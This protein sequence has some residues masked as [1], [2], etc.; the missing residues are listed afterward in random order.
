MESTQVP[1]HT[2]A[3]PI[4]STSSQSTKR[5]SNTKY[6][7]FSEQKVESD[8]RLIES[9]T[10]LKKVPSYLVLANQTERAPG[11]RRFCR[12]LGRPVRSGRSWKGCC[13]GTVARPPKRAPLRGV[14]TYDHPLGQRS[15][16]RKTRRYTAALLRGKT[17]LLCYAVLRTVC[18][19]LGHSISFHHIPLNQL[20]RHIEFHQHVVLLPQQQRQR[21]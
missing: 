11:Y 8:N 20:L 6:R 4:Y 17:V 14:S 7:E 2:H 5:Q 1:R 19:K 18:I 21:H 15:L 12:V 9:M 10:I 16:C 13:T 3:L